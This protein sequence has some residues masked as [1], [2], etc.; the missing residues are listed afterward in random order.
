MAMPQDAHDPEIGLARGTVR[1]EPY[2][3]AWA[4]R[5]A[6]EAARIQQVIGHLAVDV[7]HVGSTA[8]PGMP[9][10]PIID[11]ALALTSLRKV[12]QIMN[13][14]RGLGYTYR[15]QRNPQQ[16]LFVLGSEANRTVYLHVM[17][18]DSDAWRD[19]LL[20]RDYLRAHPDEA[21]TYAQLKQHLAHQFPQ[22][23]EAY[24]SGKAS[25]IKRIL[26]HA[27]SER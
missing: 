23:R 19:H 13:P 6:Q 8:I 3:S 21:A 24:T 12:D 26:K 14:L 27:Q 15:G 7:Q 18:N 11:I 16:P 10:K 4:Q 2:T 20:F 17:P 9:S 25:F 22:N 5:F 1:L